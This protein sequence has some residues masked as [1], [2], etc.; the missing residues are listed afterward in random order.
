M[1]AELSFRAQALEI[2]LRV[3]FKHASAEMKRTQAV[4]VEARRGELAGYGEGCPRPYVTR[5]T[6]ALSVTYDGASG[7]EPVK[8][9][10]LE[11]HIA[12]SRAS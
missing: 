12:V 11:L 3:G 4:L 2:P 1:A 9:E 7:V 5:E 8:I 10:G 6:L